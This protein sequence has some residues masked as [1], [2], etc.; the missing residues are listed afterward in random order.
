LDIKNSYSAN[1]FEE[2]PKNKHFFSKFIV[3]KNYPTVFFIITII[4]LSSM[5]FKF[6]PKF[7]S[8]FSYS[9][10]YKKKFEIEYFSE[11]FNN[12]NSF[13]LVKI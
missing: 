2:K 12:L 9:E 5:L 1:E 6:I 4:L 8:K 3:I 10:T 13:F 7:R 11:S